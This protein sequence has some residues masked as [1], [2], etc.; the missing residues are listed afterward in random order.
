MLSL[1]SS[2]QF[3]DPMKT[4]LHFFEQSVEKFHDNIY[5]WENRGGGYQGTTYGMTRGQ[6]YRMAAGLISLDVKKGDRIA[7]LSEPRNDWVICEF[8]ILFSG[9]VSV[10]LS[11]RMNE[12]RE[13]IFRLNHS[14]ARMI[15]VSGNQVGKIRQLKNELHYLEKMI[16]I[17]D[18][19]LLTAD[20][21]PVAFVK[22]AGEQFLADHRDVFEET[23]ASVTP[24]DNANIS[25]TSGTTSDPKGIILTHGNYVANIDQG[26]SL[27]DITDTCTTL[28]ILPW[29]HAFAHTAGIYCFLGKGASVASVQAGRTPL[30]SLKNIPKNISEVKPYL[31]FTVPAIAKLFKRNIEKT[32]RAKGALAGYLFEFALKV[33]SF[34]N[35]DG[36]NRGKGLKTILKP[37]IRLFDIILFRKIRLAFGGR[38]EFFIGGGALLDIEF[39]RFFYAIGIPMLQ[40]YGL[41]EAS[42]FISSNSMKHHKLG[43][44]GRVVADLELRIC[45]DQGNTLPRGEKGEIVVKGGNV[46]AG[47][48]MNVE[49]TATALKN[50][51]LHTGDIGYLDDDGYLYVLGRFKSLLI[52]DDGEKFSPEGMEEAFTSQS[53]FIDQCMLY[54]NQDPYTVILVVPGKEALLQY[55]RDK[56]LDPSS[57]EGQKASL[58]KIDQELKEYRTGNKYGAMFPQ[59]WLPAAVGVLDEGF[60]EENGLLNFQLKT[61]RGKV[62]DKYSRKISYLYTPAGKTI[63]N[64]KNMQAIRSLLS[65]HHP[66]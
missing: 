57:V 56:H 51:W 12:P 47:Y 36:W 61:V 65:A 23:V 30:E 1:F 48:W 44:S 3:C 13:I 64:E 16:V 22:T 52:S 63:V 28:L 37:L 33:T 55:L 9:A 19:P 43:S 35:G 45:D 60:T 20:E 46:M 25:Y 15:M 53:Q 66:A 24:N 29:D 49:A 54:N 39:Q 38:L 11:V 17:D 26:Y 27:M 59:R 31:L 42:P 6:V 62:V 34:Y 5:L 7:L 40:G 2:C 14:G 8:G 21:I 32:I 41:T 10:P 18:V 4:L 50:G 58:E